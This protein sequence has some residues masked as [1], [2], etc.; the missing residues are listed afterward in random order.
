M[1]IAFGALIGVAVG[2]G[3]VVFYRLIDLAYLFFHEL[4]EQRLG[5]LETAIYRPVLTA[6]GI[7]LAWLIVRWARIPPGQNIP[8]I[9][10]AVA[11]KGGR[12]PLRPVL[13][14]LLASAVT[15]G[16]GGSAGSEGPVATLGGGLGSSL[17]KL[18]RLP[19][20]HRRVL[21]GCGAAAGISGAFGAP[22][23]GA[24]FALE[25][26]IGSFSVGAFSPVV[27]AS[28]AGALTVR[29]LLGAAPVI[30]VP[31]QIDMVWWAAA[32]L[33]PLLGVVCGLVSA[34]YSRVFFATADRF[35]RVPGPPWLKPVIGGLL[36][37]ALALVAA[38][39][40]TG[41]GH[42]R[43]PAALF[44]GRAWYFLLAIAGL[45]VLMT[46]IT[47][48]AGGSGGVFTP[49]LFVGAALGGGIG[50][51]AQTLFPDLPLHPASLGLVG[52]AG[53]VAGATRAPIT[54]IF[55]VFE[56]TDNYELV[57]PLMIV[58]V[59]AFLTARRLTPYGL[60]DGWLARRGEHLSH[61]ADRALMERILVSDAMS[62]DAVSVLPD[63]TLAQVVAA[64]EVARQLTLPVVDR[65]G[66]LIGL[67]RHGELRDALLEHGALASVI[68][69]ADLA[70]ETPSVTPVAT[71]RDAMR[72]LNAGALDTVPVVASAAPGAVRYLGMLS[73]GDV[74]E[75]YERA[76]VEEV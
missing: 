6:L 74:L 10:L 27:I 51:L 53:L 29:P 19:S 47:L 68:L 66:M 25:E 59:I 8:D 3:V 64:S 57:L 7:L 48:A 31:A 76:L 20:R 70:E 24:F 5:S 14:R 46:S 42:L 11:K 63:A 21:V 41:D 39:L 61:G 55:M 34:G 23:A 18:F 30:D 22:F 54:A 73:R 43:I 58:S 2:L 9:Q 15:L 45:K 16:S 26:V 71:L 60:Y 32:V 35:E 12:V 44:G 72:A 65:E 75:A 28:V 62:R 36:V 56:I 49:T 37:G 4:P 69:A 33:F 67:I 17:A 40:L 52:M 38:G 1:L 13:V 50:V